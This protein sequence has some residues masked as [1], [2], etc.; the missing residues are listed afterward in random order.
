MELNGARATAATACC[1]GDELTG[2][3]SRPRRAFATSESPSLSPLGPSPPWARGLHSRPPFYQL[4]NTEICGFQLQNCRQ[5]H[6]REAKTAPKLKHTFKAVTSRAAGWER[7]E[8]GQGKLSRAPALP[9]QRRGLPQRRRLPAAT[10]LSL[11]EGLRFRHRHDFPDL[12]SPGRSVSIAD[13]ISLA[14]NKPS[15][16]ANQLR[17]CGSFVLR[18]PDQAEQPRESIHLDANPRRIPASPA[19]DSREAETTQERS[20]SPSES[21]AAR[22]GRC[23]EK[24]NKKVSVALQ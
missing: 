20:P 18:T 24:N 15:R 10:V 14:P 3:V 16:S 1:Q 5:I 23:G 9:R 12:V 2:T 8:S 7:A 19:T 17:N 6:P 4:K 21:L 22:R 11:C 13:T